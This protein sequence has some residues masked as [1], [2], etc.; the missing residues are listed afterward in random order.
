LFLTF[1][2]EINIIKHDSDTS[3]RIIIEGKKYDCN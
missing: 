1:A 3:T 2:R